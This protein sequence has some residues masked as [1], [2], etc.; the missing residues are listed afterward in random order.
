MPGEF[1]YTKILCPID[2]DHDSTAVLKTIESLARLGDCTIVLLNVAPI[3]VHGGG[4]ADVN[5]AQVDFANSR[6][7]EIAR[8]HLAGL[9]FETMAPAGDPANEI[10]KAATEARIDLIVMAKHGHKGLAHLIIGSV[11]EKVIRQAPCP[12][13]AVPAGKFDPKK[14][15]DV[16]MTRHPVTAAADETLESIQTKMEHGGFRS[17][18]IVTDGKPIGIITDRDLRLFA[19]KHKDVL[20]RDAMSEALVTVTPATSLKEAARIL[21]EHKIDCLPVVT[22][23]GGLAGIITTT[24]VMSAVES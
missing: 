5:K 17:I 7:E 21:K 15:V 16:W 11:A 10:L 20:A 12:V 2:F 14:T 8:K 19:G 22:D 18:P 13:L 3:V 23:D 6:L 4:F 9:R 1:P 24:D